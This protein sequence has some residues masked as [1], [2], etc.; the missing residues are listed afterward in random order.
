MGWQQ[1]R[2]TMASPSE[3]L[4]EISTT[5]QV[6]QFNALPAPVPPKIT[7]NGTPFPSPGQLHQP[8]GYQ[9][10]VIDATRDYTDPASILANQFINFFASSGTNSWASTYQYTYGAIKRAILNSGNI[11]QQLIILASYGMD[12][13]MAP[14]NE[15]YEMLLGAGAGPTLQYWET[16]CNPGSQ[17]GNPTSWVST[18]ANY[19]FV[20]FSARTY[21]Q[22]YEV[23]EIGSPVTSNL[24]VTLYNPVPPSPS[25]G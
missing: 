24:S 25:S 2:I 21:G 7:M 12:N 8:S 17:T 20:G 3:I 13:N 5:S 18:P 6:M 9:L 15:A 19:I 14:T 1:E 11:D 4:L 22:G 16:H 10:I 23:H